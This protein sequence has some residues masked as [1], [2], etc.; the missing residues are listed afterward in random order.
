MSASFHP[1][2]KKVH[3]AL[4]ALVVIL[5]ITAFI[6]KANY[7]GSAVSCFREMTC[8]GT[9]FAVLA[10]VAASVQRLMELK[11]GRNI[12]SRWGYF[13]HL[14]SAVTEV[15]ILLVVLIGLLPIVKDH[16]VFAR[17]DMINMHVIIPLIT[18][19]TFVRYAVCPEGVKTIDRL[20]G[21]IFIILYAVTMITLILLNVV[22][23]EKIPYSFLNVRKAAVWY[24]ALAA[25]AAVTIS[26]FF[27]NL[28]ME[29]NQRMSRKVKAKE[30]N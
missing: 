14:S 19:F 20:N 18:M 17:Y 25:V 11:R 12:P 24:L 15:L 16:P 8:D 2:Q 22:P 3:I 13:L 30:E 7:E 9:L 5:G 28:F 4:N 10:A 6:Y 21:L 26:L 27:S 23:E 29:M 1:V